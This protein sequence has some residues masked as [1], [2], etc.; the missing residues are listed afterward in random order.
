[1][2]TVCLRPLYA[3]TSCIHHIQKQ[4]AE[5]SIVADRM[6]FK[7]V[8][9]EEILKKRKLSKKLAENTLYSTEARPA[10]IEKSHHLDQKTVAPADKVLESTPSGAPEP[11]DSIRPKD[12]PSP[13]KAARN[14]PVS[15]MDLEK[16]DLELL[17]TDK[18]KLFNLISLFLKAL[19]HEQKQLASE[20]K[21]NP[22]T[23]ASLPEIH[24]QCKEHLKPF[25][26]LLKKQSLPDDILSSLASICSLMQKR[27]Y[28]AANDVYLKLAI[29]NAPWPIG[30]T[31]VGIHE[32]SAQEK[33]KSNQVARK[34]ILGFL[35]RHR[36]TERRSLAQM[37][38][39]H[40]AAY[41]LLS[42]RISSQGKI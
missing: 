20:T 42:S 38:T 8:L 1:M 14:P 10:D 36:C 16:I 35:I 7:E 11:K 12:S 22:D 25:F 33:I 26:K 5:Y 29:G 30:V 21:K 31:A 4:A 41:H 23:P 13:G 34:S 24:K 32:R 9:S 2:I 18:R 27:E 37:D 19:L 3:H 40:K 17:K 39:S 15:A 28:V 6:D